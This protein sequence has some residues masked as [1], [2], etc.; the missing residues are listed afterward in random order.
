MN[1]HRIIR[2]AVRSILIQ[3]GP[4]TCSEL[5]RNI[6][7]DPKRH[8]GTIHAV[9]VDMEKDGILG[10]TFTAKGKR[11]Q[12]FIFPGAIRNRDRIAAAFIG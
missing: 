11:D 9:M 10:A 5:V 3:K 2:I 1:F 4:Q 8:K 6:G 12:W 7:L